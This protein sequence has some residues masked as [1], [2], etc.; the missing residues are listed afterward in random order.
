MHRIPAL[1]LL[2]M[3]A[4][5]LLAACDEAG[6][7]M[8][9]VVRLNHLQVIGT[10]N[11]YHVA[12]DVAPP[13][14]AEM[15]YT[16]PPI[17][18]Q[19]QTYG[20][21]QLELDVWETDDGVFNCYHGMLVDEGSRCRDLRDCLVAAKA[22]SDEHPRH[23]PLVFIMEVKQVF[24]V[25]SPDNQAQV[26]ASGFFD[27]LEGLF[28]DVFGRDRILTPDDVRG[29]AA[30]LRQ[31]LVQTGWPTLGAVRGKSMFVLN[32]TSERIG[33][34]DAYLAKYPGLKGALLFAKKDT[35]DDWGAILEL[36]NVT[37]DADAIRAGLAANYLVRGAADG[38]GWDEAKDRELAPL[39]PPAG[40]H[41]I[42]TDFLT[43]QPDHEYVFSWPF[44]H[45]VRC[46]PVTAPP[47]CDD[48]RLE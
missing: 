45:P 21:R 1:P 14:P 11:S 5:P 19:L 46:N 20:V 37:R 25:D 2:A 41:W 16:Q 40:I 12:P 31:A 47:E 26:L 23:V 36:N 9:D 3:L 15:N 7:S 32:T 44:P 18:D 35:N 24:A 10:H 29:D 6:P 34:M 33:I 38:I 8:D 4:L 42:N 48:A 30:T 22:W 39:T 43:K 13:I 17:R 27:D 28:R